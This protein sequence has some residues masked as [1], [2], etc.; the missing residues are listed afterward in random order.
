MIHLANE[1]HLQSICRIA[2]RL[3][4]KVVGK[5]AEGP[6]AFLELDVDMGKPHSLALANLQELRKYFASNQI[7]PFVNKGLGKPIQVAAITSVA[8]GETEYEQ[9]VR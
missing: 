4:I 3:Q 6:S 2:L 9:Y 5:N 7:D 1:C 8:V